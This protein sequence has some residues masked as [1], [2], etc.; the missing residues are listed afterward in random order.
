MPR[1][2]LGNLRSLFGEL[3]RRHVVQIVVA[4]AVF[5]AA[6]IGVA[7]DVAPALDLPSRTT[8]IVVVLALLGLPVAALLAWFYEV[9]RE[10]PYGETEDAAAPAGVMRLAPL[11]TPPTPLVGREHELAYATRLLND[12][13][14]RILT[15]AGPGG[16]GKTRLAIELASRSAA[17]FPDGVCFASLSGVESVDPLPAVIAESLGLPLS[18]REGAAEQLLAALRDR[19]MLLLLDNFEQLSAGG[20]LLAAIAERAPGVRLLVTSRARLGLG[21]ETVLPLQGLVFPDVAEGRIRNFDAVR[22]FVQSARRVNP[23]FSAGREAEHVAR[24]CRLV[25]GIPLALELAGACVNVLSC[26]EIAEEIEREHDLGLH[27]RRDLPERHRSLRAAFESSWRL[28]GA[29]E[30]RAFRALSV[31][32]AGFTREAAAA[33]G[34][35]LRLIAA[36]SDKSLVR[37]SDAGRFWILEVLRQFSAEKLHANADEERLVTQLHCE[38][39][40]TRL[41]KLAAEFDGPDG[42]G[43]LAHIA[44]EGNDVRVAWGRA[45]ATADLPRLARALPG[46]FV[47]FNARGWV[48]EGG[49][50]LARAIAA[51]RDAGPAS[52]PQGEERRRA[53]ARLLARRGAFLGYLGT[54]REA[55]E[56]L[57]ESIRLLRESGDRAEQA[58]A[59]GYLSNIARAAGE[60]DDSHAFASES[61]EL[62]RAVGDRA[63]MA[64][65]LNG[66]GA[67]A[68][69]RADY[70]EA[71]RRY[72]DSVA[73]YRDIGAVGELWQPLNNLG[74]IA[75]LSGDYEEARRLLEENL[76][77]ARERQNLRGVCYLL[78]N[79][80]VV[81]SKAGDDDGAEPFLRESAELARQLGFRTQLALSLSVL[82]N[83]Q[84][85]RGEDAA[86]RETLLRALSLAVEMEQTPLAL[87]IL[88]G[89]AKLHVRRGEHE[90]ALPLLHAIVVHPACDG[91]SRA[92]AETQLEFVRG[93][94]PD[95]RSAPLLDEV[96]EQMLHAPTA[97]GA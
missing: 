49:E 91:E 76:A 23:R 72:R 58:F 44:E 10:T 89:M 95:D 93:Q 55:R 86:G 14:T 68:Q 41:E 22:L 19:Q 12:S 87:E 69:M 57:S 15:L 50:L 20:E 73:L 5:A 16:V 85:G 82:G 40:T 45:V 43:V 74:A 62:Y 56:L 59:L 8:T 11:P 24:I 17:A 7:S 53:L 1:R 70:A 30:Q 92:E 71:Q 78:H 37:R 96:L 46:F 51:L 9:K 54:A 39:F 32:R 25:E 81:A 67:V 21:A 97:T 18:A 3:R 33:V 52:G 4:Y 38:Y 79:L 29:E 2:K 94:V 84:A 88:L 27:L 34:V 6:V 65:A 35:E 83:I 63:G 61:L 26:A 60:Y 48:Q 75:S 66:L 80:G 42:P 64:R 36:L 90:H 31:F 47:L 13:A 77:Y 28:L